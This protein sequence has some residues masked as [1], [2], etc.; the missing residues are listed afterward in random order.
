M[1]FGLPPEFLDRGKAGRRSRLWQNCLSARRVCSAAIA[2]CYERGTPARA[3][4]KKARPGS[5]QITAHPLNPPT[6]QFSHYLTKDMALAA[7]DTNMKVA[8]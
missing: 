2:D 7:G 5:G 6:L 1:A 3:A 4:G 8:V